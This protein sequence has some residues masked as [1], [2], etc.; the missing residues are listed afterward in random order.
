[1]PLF[2]ER[3]ATWA[4]TDRRNRKSTPPR[5]LLTVLASALQVIVSVSGVVFFSEGG[6][7]VAIGLAVVAI[8]LAVPRIARIRRYRRRM[9]ALS[10]PN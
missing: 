6:K 3:Y 5:T 7:F 10:A 2:G 8:V 9:S 4:A 1:M